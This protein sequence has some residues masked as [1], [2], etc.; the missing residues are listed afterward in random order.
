MRLGQTH[1]HMT[2]IHDVEGLPYNN[3]V[4]LCKSRS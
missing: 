2:C 3:K 4:V 1:P